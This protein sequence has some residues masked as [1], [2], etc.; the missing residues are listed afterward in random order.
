MNKIL[1]TYEYGT[2][3][4]KS[5]K[6]ILSSLH[7]L[8]SK[9]T[10]SMGNQYR[11]Q[12]TLYVLGL[13]FHTQRREQIWTDWHK[14]T[15]SCHHSLADDKT[16]APRTLDDNHSMQVTMKLGTEL[17]ITF[18][19]GMKHYWRWR[20]NGYMIANLIKSEYRLLT[21][22]NGKCQTVSLWQHCFAK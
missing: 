4:E 16:D 14:E 7:F 10:E 1:C 12:P 22:T 21:Y 18:S 13:Y 3:S 11:A 15:P 5:C 19:V 8:K 6:L 2:G 17:I 9:T 20:G